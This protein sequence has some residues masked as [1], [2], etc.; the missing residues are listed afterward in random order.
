VIY[1]EAG[2]QI[3]IGDNCIFRSDATSNLIGVNRKCILSAHA[4]HTIIH[5]GKN[6]AFSGTSIGAKECIE[7]GDNVLI[8]AN[9]VI[10]DFDWHT[11][12]PLNR[13]DASKIKAKKVVIGDNVWIGLG[14]TI[15]KGVHIGENAVIGAGSV[16][17]SDIPSNS[18]CAGNPCK[19]IKK[20]ERSD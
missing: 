5:I 16:V 10:T 19:L 7:I 17:V 8:G 4:S 20:I 2:A 11:L 13:D 1:K 18:I 15:L 9:S 12:D 6:C 14:C 3:N